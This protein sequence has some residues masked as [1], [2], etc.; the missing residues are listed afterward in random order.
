MSKSPCLPLDQLSQSWT[1]RALCHA[2]SRSVRPRP[3][4]FQ[5]SVVCG[6]PCVPRGPA[7]MKGIP[8]SRIPITP[9]VP[10][11]QPESSS[12][13]HCTLLP[14]DS[15]ARESV[16]DSGRQPAAATADGDTVTISG[17]SGSPLE[18]STSNPFSCNI[19]KRSYTR[20]DH[21]ARHYRSHT[22]EKP[23]ECET[24][25]KGFARA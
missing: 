15:S 17:P 23:F 18:L 10:P 7:G 8:T 16:M 6:A 25:G 3:T 13:H 24:C 1:D 14:R 2:V 22:R 19:C 12:L 20:V 9:D 21:L 4:P 5:G 11:H